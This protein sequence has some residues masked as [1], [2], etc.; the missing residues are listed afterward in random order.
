M[1]G[2]FLI[3]YVANPSTVIFE[4]NSSIMSKNYVQRVDV[5]GYADSWSE[6]V[7]TRPD[8]DVSYSQ[9]QTN[10]NAYLHSSD[11][12]TPI[13]TNVANV[14][15][16]NTVAVNVQ[17][18]VNTN[19]VN[20]NIPVTVTNQPTVHLSGTIDVRIVGT[21]TL[22]VDILS[23]I[24]LPINIQQ[25]IQLPVDIARSVQ[26]PAFIVNTT[27]LL[28]NV[29]NGQFHTIVDNPV[30]IA[31]GTPIHAIIDNVVNT[32]I[33]GIPI[34]ETTIVGIDLPPRSTVEGNEAVLDSR[35]VLPVTIG[36]H[37]PD[38]ANFV[39]FADAYRGA[40]D[41][42][43]NIL[44]THTNPLLNRTSSIASPPGLLR[45]RSLSLDSLVYIQAAEDER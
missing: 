7:I 40:L 24:L 8:M 26:I 45:S 34:T 19:V 14:N 36:Q 3:Y 20:T 4:Y 5:Y 16:V 27:P 29:V 43:Y 44:V 21:V 33:E 39:R 22:P 10:I 9:I 2:E 1:Q 30:S 42:H 23:S 13:A 12:F 38:S 15:V 32:V 31:P 28:T 18:T 41:P 11:S 6:S 25:T 37:N 35:Y 17:N